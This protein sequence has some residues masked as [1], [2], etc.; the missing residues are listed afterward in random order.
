[1][2]EF[3]L[4]KNKKKTSKRLNVIWKRFNL[5]CIRF[6][7]ERKCFIRS[8]IENKINRTLGY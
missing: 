6:N 7:L 2:V 8:Y 3:N 5:I 4:Q 1:M